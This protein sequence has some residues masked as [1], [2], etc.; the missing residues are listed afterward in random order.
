MFCGFVEVV[1][2]KKTIKKTNKK[3]KQQ[4]LPQLKHLPKQGEAKGIQIKLCAW[5]WSKIKRFFVFFCFPL[6]N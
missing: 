1:L 6:P 3:K 5:C 2:P 4:I